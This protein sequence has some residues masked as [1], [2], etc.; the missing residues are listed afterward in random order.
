MKTVVFLLIPL[1]WNHQNRVY[2]TLIEPFR[3][4][5]Y[6]VNPV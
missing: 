4:F 2:K 6:Q 3:F 5:D 1:N